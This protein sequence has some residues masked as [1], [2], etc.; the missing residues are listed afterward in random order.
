[1]AKEQKES[2]VAII[3]ST[4]LHP[5]DKEEEKELDLGSEEPDAPLPLTVTSRVLYM[6]GD[7]TAG[8]AYRFS[9]WLESVRKRS[10]KYRSS[11]FPR[12]LHGLDSMPSGSG[13]L[14]V[15]SK[16]E[17]PPEQV[18]EISLWERLGKA[19]VLDIESSSFSWDMLSSLHHTEHSS[20]TEQSEDELNNKAL[21]VTVNS[22][23]V[24]FFA[25]FNQHGNDD[26]FPKEAAAVIK[27]SSS[28]M[29]IQSERLGYEFAKWLGVRT[30]QAR[31]I[32]NCSTEW[33]QIKEAAEKARL[34]A[35]SEGDEVGEVTCSELLEALELSRCLLLMSYIHGSPL[36]E[37][38]AAFESR[39]TA[40]RTAAA[41]GRVLM[42]DLVIRNEDRLP[43]RQ[44][45]WRGNAA[46]L[47]LADN[48][49][50]VDMNALED[51]FDSAINRYRPRVMRALQKERRA[52]SLHSRL[53]S[54]EPEL[55]SQGSDLSDVTE[56]PK[57]SNRSLRSQTSD[58]SIS[59][60]LHNFR[61]VAID[62]GVPRRPPAGKRANDQANYPKLVELLLN[63]SDYSSN[64]LY[65][66]TGGKLGYP[67][68]EDT[69]TTDIRTTEVSS[70]VQEFRSG[71][72]AALRDLQ[73][74]HI[75]LLTLH[76]K[77]D[78]SL[79]AFL[80]ITSKTSG[81]SD[82]EDIAVPESPLHGFANCPSP[83]AQSKERVLNDNHPDFSDSELQR[84][85]PR[86]ASSGSKETSD[87]R[88]PM[89]R[90]S[91]PGKFSK[92]S[93]EPLQSLRLTSKIRDIHKCAKV[94]TE[95][96]K[97]LELWN[98]MLR[99]DAIKLC[100]ENN[101]NT[102]FFEGSDNNCV[103]DAYELKV[104]L[105]HILERISLISDAA[106]T[107]K[108]SSITNSLFIGGALA[109]GSTYTLQ[110]IGITHILCL[111]AN[112][113]GQSDSQY[114]DLFEYRNYSICDS[115]DSNI[116]SIFEEA[117]DFIDDVESKGR[118]V[119]V[120]CF[121]GKSRS[122]TLVLAYL[123]LRKNFTLLEAWNALKRVHRRAQPNDGFART[124]LDLDCK[125][126]GKMSMEWQQRRPT[127][128]VCPICGKNAGLSSSSLKLHL[129]KSHKKLSSGSVDSA[130]TMEIQKALEALKMT[131]SGSVSPSTQSASVMDDLG[132][133]IPSSF[134]TTKS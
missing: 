64:L 110:H 91:W 24:V 118:K 114:P 128:K 67:S 26:A 90:E 102:G 133:P 36:L 77:L 32:H 107:E 132:L 126:H 42:L 80:N 74:F 89:S 85:A 56:S 4:T 52:T 22:G 39:E 29:A 120:H 53:S 57:S 130:M 23:G 61:I 121:E 101:F 109:A 122:A 123:M 70:G 127:M 72:R 82:K 47:L 59:S 125:L 84:T 119:L 98:E 13:E 105:E 94:D 96:N 21:E 27:F 5:Q 131:R 50:S 28:R 117:S 108:P 95:S 97:E 11:G 46:N 78:S 15:D 30:P 86:S 65:D 54:H 83:P 88:S 20:S 25:L 68:L 58:E 129:Q 41:L 48:V 33:L 55:V 45:R 79:R 87:C 81:D 3:N 111:C 106:N 99:N 60:E 8:P 63:C 62:S 18:P 116:S 12:R 51:A 124:L 113:T 35:T 100:Q 2:S 103:V 16:S 7:I 115:E 34:S 104:R 93:G 71:F 40:E 17:P 37:S 6:L 44:L 10:A 43:C 75:F 19:A 112:E 134:A 66:I 9:Q 31:V 49:L 69:H 38:S 14:L 73:S 1:M 76:Q 92:G